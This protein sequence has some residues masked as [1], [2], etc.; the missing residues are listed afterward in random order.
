MDGGRGI[1]KGEDGV[2]RGAKKG[3]AISIEK[4]EMG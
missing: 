3:N 2:S 1:G 4:R